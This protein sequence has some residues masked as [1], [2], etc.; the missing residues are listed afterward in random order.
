L[1]V[2]ALQQRELLDPMLG[3]AY[4]A[5]KAAGKQVTAGGIHADVAQLCQQL[6]LTGSRHLA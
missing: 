1:V 3:E 6:I 5:A 4:I 2:I